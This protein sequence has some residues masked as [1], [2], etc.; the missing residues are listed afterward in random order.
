MKAALPELKIQFAEVPTLPIPMEETTGGLFIGDIKRRRPVGELYIKSTQSAEDKDLSLAH[1][2]GHAIDHYADWFSDYLTPTEVGELRKVYAAVRGR[3]A[4]KPAE[5]EEFGYSP[6]DVNGELAAEGFRAYLTD[7]NWFKAVAPR[8]AARF[9]AEV[10][11][12]RYLK[13][14]IQFNSLGAAGLLS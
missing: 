9:R 12:N 6:F 1:E 7:P 11:R 10:N 14:I 8:S 4:K 13:H 2:L 3:Y 5:P